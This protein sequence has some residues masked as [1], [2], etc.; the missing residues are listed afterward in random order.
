MSEQEEVLFK[1]ECNSPD[2]FLRCMLTLNCLSDCKYC[3]A[4]V[5]TLP[6]A[7]KD[8]VLPVAVW[9]EGINRRMRPVLFTGGEPFLYNKLPDLINML[10]PKIQ[11]RIYTNLQH[12]V[13][14]FIRKVSR[15]VSFVASLH[16][17]TPDLEVWCSRFVALRQKNPVQITIVGSG[18]WPSLGEFLL[19]QDVVEH[20]TVSRDQRYM[21]K[22]SGVET[23]RAHPQVRCSSRIYQYGPNGFRYV[24]VKLMGLGGEFG[25]FEHISEPMKPHLLEVTNCPHFGLCAACSNL[26]EGIVEDL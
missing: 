9:A 12:D 22:S 3:S 25:R 13:S 20:F 5:T 24:C 23:N 18:D 6:S 17:T 16:P 14:Q 2:Q 1:K 15:P 26:V 21:V 10:D 19:Q 11:V 8:S 4:L 7:I